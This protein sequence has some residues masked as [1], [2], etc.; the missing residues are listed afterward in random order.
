MR[1]DEAVPPN[2][3]SVVFTVKGKS[4]LIIK[5]RTGS[6]NQ[7]HL[8][9]RVSEDP[10]PES[11]LSRLSF[12]FSVSLTLSCSSSADSRL[13]VKSSATNMIV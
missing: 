4:G 8:E 12:A 2:P 9:T 13:P 6:K 5:K 10:T 7:A 3:L 1:L 11:R